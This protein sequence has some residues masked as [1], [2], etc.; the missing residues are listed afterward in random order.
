MKVEKH[1][2]LFNGKIY[3][4]I[5]LIKFILLFFGADF[6]FFFTFQFWELFRFPHLLHVASIGKIKCQMKR[7]KCI[8]HNKDI[9]LL[10]PFV[11]IQQSTNV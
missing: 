8:Q 5:F 7:W 2:F 1:F 3:L 4:F 6:I 10:Y 9:C 11:C